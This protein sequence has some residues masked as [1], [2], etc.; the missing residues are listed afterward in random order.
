VVRRGTG[1]TLIAGY[2]WFTDWGRDTFIA[3]RGIALACG[4]YDLAREVLLEWSGS[5]S[6]GMLPNRFP[7]GGGE[8][9]YNA[10]D[11]SLWFVI[12]ASEL[13]RAMANAGRPLDA[14]ARERLRAAAEA[15]LTGYTRGT[16]YGIRHDR[17]GLLMAGEAGVQL[18]WMD[19][20]VEGRPI[21]PRTGKPVE[22]Q[23]LWINALAAA[24]KHSAFWRAQAERS[25]AAFAKRFW[26][27]DRGC[28]Y[29][30]IDVDGRAGAVDPTLR[31][32]QILAVGGLPMPVL[33]GERARS[34]VDVVEREL[35]T[36]LG[37]RSLGPREPGY[38]ARYAGGPAER[39][40]SYH[41]GP[42]WAWLLGPFV[43]AWLSV[44]GGDERARREA[45]DR[46]HAPLV[47]HL[48][49]AGLGHV[50]ELADAE[51]PYT[52]RGC[53]FQA[54]SV[55]EM[56]RIERLLGALARPST[57]VAHAALSPRR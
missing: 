11:A 54:W 22:I 8:P 25:A 27:P 5:V 7:D 52:P 53:P 30:V 43:E 57:G 51:P 3:L 21:T 2:P 16:R 56:L 40:G 15:I 48:G 9:E 44:R 49:T 19:A 33:T 4:R 10:V 46:F 32:N 36:P 41:Q 12:V 17:D 1:R 6:G 13:D 26:N 29:D 18:T 34:V 39:D 55:G 37:L 42:A 38:R 35:W 45:H 23:A 50:S 47:E 24:G 20:R 28:L 31:P 14:D